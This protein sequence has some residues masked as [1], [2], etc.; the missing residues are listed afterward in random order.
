MSIAGYLRLFFIAIVLSAGVLVAPAPA[1]AY[2]T[3]GNA[4][5]IDI[6]ADYE[7]NQTLT[8]YLT[9]EA[10]TE[11][12]FIELYW[13]SQHSI[14]LEGAYPPFDPSRTVETSYEVN[15][16]LEYMPP[17][18]DIVYFWRVTEEDG[19][20]S[21]S[22]QQTLF[23][24]DDTQEWRTLT[25]GLTTL[26]WYT[27]SESF[28]QDIIDT[29]NRAIERLSER[30][31]A[32]LDEPIRII[33]YGD[34][35]A[36]RNALSGGSVEWVGGLAYPSDFLVVAMIADGRGSEAE[37]RRMIP[38]EVSHL[39]F[40]QATANPFNSA[41]IWLNEGL[42]VYN[43]ETPDVDHPD[44]IAEA[45]E[46]GRLIPLRAL[47][48]EFPY[49]P[50]QAS[51]SYAESESVVTYI[52]EEHGDDRMAALIAIFR[53]EVSQEEALQ[54][55]LGMSIDELDAAWKDWLGYAGD[56]TASTNAAPVPRQTVDEDQPILTDNEQIGFGIVAALG[57]LAGL[58]LMIVSFIQ[59]RKR[60]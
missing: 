23:Y 10:D 46:E 21:E 11:I 24:M 49:D 31:D 6:S 5:F 26:Y 22:E 45:V 28:A 41:P 56:R 4:R 59:Y 57:M 18:L 55:T 52:I 16:R 19:S 25:D 43:Q 13:R 29:A 39:V 9:A 60:P 42:A 38:H 44:L 53:T 33:I 50:D 58:A 54:A 40:E 12:E 30:F 14:D 37:I 47:S 32:T 8:F 35:G 34:R 48:S 20:V 51:L 1:P 27:G 2:A 15:L 17:G 3:E 7:F 36:F